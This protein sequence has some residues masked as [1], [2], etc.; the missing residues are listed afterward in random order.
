MGWYAISVLGCPLIFDLLVEQK[1]L[2]GN[3]FSFYLTK[4]PGEEGSSLVLGGVNPKYADGEFKYYPLKMENYWVLEMTDVIF[5][6]T[7]YKI[8]SEQ[9]IGIID[10]GTSVIAGP[11]AVVEKMTAG[12][13]PGRQK[14]V[15]CSKLS[16][17]PDLTF[18]FSGD[19]YVLKPEDY[20]LKVTEGQQTACIVGIIPLDL[21]HS[22][23]EAFIVGDS[24]LKTYYT[25]FDVEGERIGFVRS[26]AK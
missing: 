5:N 8:K 10:T 1:Q 16:E 19:N 2:S 7:S 4:N 20:I 23:G 11:K 22:L 6:G 12:F 18:Q 15:D 24:F 13:G 21:P 9:L 14:Q 17:L 25:H 26:K 3:S